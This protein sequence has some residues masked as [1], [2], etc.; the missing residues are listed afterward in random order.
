[1]P[2]VPA[3]EGKGCG[4]LEDDVC[5]YLGDYATYL[6]ETGRATMTTY[7]EAVERMK[8][9]EENGYMHQITNGDGP[10]EIFAICNCTL[11]SCYGLRC[12]QLFNN[13][14]MS[15]SAYRAKVDPDKC[16]ACGK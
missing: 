16:V 4:E 2:Q 1:M 14:N 7:E 13:P 15:A 8:R 9:T 6:V 10:D 11:G 12:S 5:V 3:P